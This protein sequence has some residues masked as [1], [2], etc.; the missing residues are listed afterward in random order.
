MRTKQLLKWMLALVLACVLPAGAWAQAD[1]GSG[2]GWRPT[3][4]GGASLDTD[5]QSFINRAGVTNLTGQQR[6]NGFVKAMKYHGLWSL[7]YD[8][9]PMSSLMQPSNG[10]DLVSMKGRFT[11]LHTTNGPLRGVRGISFDGVNDRIFGITAD[12]LT[13]YTMTAQMAGSTNNSGAPFMLQ[14]LD[15]QQT[16]YFAIAAPAAGY[17]VAALRTMGLGGAATSDDIVHQLNVTYCWGFNHL[18]DVQKTVSFATDNSGTANT[19]VW[20]DGQENLN[21]GNKIT[22][23]TY[24]TGASV[25]NMGSSFTNGNLGN[26]AQMHASAIILCNSFL[27]YSQVSNLNECIRWLDPAPKN[28]VIMGDSY[29]DDQPGAG[30]GRYPPWCPWPNAL[31]QFASISNDYRII[32]KAISGMSSPFIDYS[33]KARPFR[34]LVGGVEEAWL[35]FMLG[36]NDA[37]NGNNSASVWALIDAFIMKARADGFRVFAMTY[38]HSQQMINTPAVST[39]ITNLATVMSYVLTNREKFDFILRGENV[40]GYTNIVNAEWNGDT[41][42]PGAEGERR[43]ANALQSALLGVRTGPSGTF[44][45][46][47]MTN[48]GAGATDLLFRWQLGNELRDVGDQITYTLSGGF[49]NEVTAAKLV[50][51]VYGSEEVLNSGSMALHKGPWSAQVKI[52]LLGQNSQ[53]VESTFSG[54]ATNFTQTTFATQ[55]NFYPTLVKVRCTGAQSGQITNNWLAWDWRP[56]K[57]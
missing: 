50:T 15:A 31:Q 7:A 16:N 28:I 47:P 5:A 54:T 48:N 13:T 35:G 10:N 51:F 1:S 25:L 24:A 38:P 2:S 57:P 19:V 40:I 56:I 21:L 23:R 3:A 29:S 20:V 14:F 4:S 32:N 6:I 9:V 12:V 8:V 36:Y 46:V 49:T 41:I 30:G 33:F 26:F 39:G 42:H 53:R 52:T 18:V 44:W 22:A 27:T 43:L 55:T 45:S 34:P 37:L 11:T 17:Q